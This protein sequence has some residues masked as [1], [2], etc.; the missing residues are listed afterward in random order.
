MADHG[1][2]AINTGVAELCSFGQSARND[3]SFSRSI[4]MLK[5]SLQLTSAKKPA[6]V[7]QNRLRFPRGSPN[8]GSHGQRKRSFPQDLCRFYVRNSPLVLLTLL[9]TILVIHWRLNQ[10]EP[11]TQPS[12]FHGPAVHENGSDAR[13]L[14]ATADE[15]TKHF[16][17]YSVVLHPVI[18]RSVYHPKASQPLRVIFMGR[19]EGPLS[20]PAESSQNYFPAD[21]FLDGLDRSAYLKVIQWI[22]YDPIHRTVQT[23]NYHSSPHH[24]PL[25]VVVDWAGFSRDCHALERAWKDSAL[26]S[27]VTERDNV[28]LLFLDISASAKTVACSNLLDW[29]PKER[30]RIARRGIIHGRH[31]N[32]TKG[33]IE[34]GH[35]E[36]NDGSVLSGGPLLHL[37]YFLREAFVTQLEAVAKSGGVDVAALVLKGP[38]KTDISH[39]WRKGD[40]S[41]YSFLRQLIG[42]QVIEFD[43]SV[44]SKHLRW[45]VRIIGDGDAME[46]HQVDPEYVAG[47]VSSKI[48]VIAQKDEWEDHYRLME[49]LASGA[50]V[51]SDVMLAPPNGLKNR[52]N[53][54]FYDS[55]SSLRQLLK[56]YTDPQQTEKS[57]SIARKG[58]EYA[59]G[60]HRSWH[61][62]EAILFGT[63]LTIVDKPTEA[64]PHR[65]HPP[66]ASN[67]HA[68]VMVATA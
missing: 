36:P 45:T 35:V 42:S 25:V 1:A 12:H 34:T 31:W 5:R 23:H 18:P 60:R 21:L 10:V 58:F 15:A 3:T 63:P 54:V 41:H 52:T 61:H 4:S 22:E 30:I 14:A 48:V 24:E 66:K 65:I 55:P 57:A 9:G 59:M 26:A 39:F 13:S 43:E 64:A 47:L 6:A 67:S 49:S 27:L 29:I 38:R 44:P 56:Y 11:G 62:M 51:L 17:D 53:I 7:V 40:Y 68:Y 32:Q 28:Y 33:W 37:P 46:V 16:S 20:A 50:L 19:K 8:G 2:L